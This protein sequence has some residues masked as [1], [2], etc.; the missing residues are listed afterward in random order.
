MWFSDRIAA[1]AISSL[2]DV[3]RQTVSGMDA[4]NVPINAIPMAVGWGA[5]PGGR[6]K[7]VG[8]GTNF[9]DANLIGNYSMVTVFC[10][11]RG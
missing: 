8:A 7:A 5:V 9:H 10:N 1:C 3:A 4:Q 6:A 2:H 11:R